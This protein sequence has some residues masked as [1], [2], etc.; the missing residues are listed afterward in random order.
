MLITN[1]LLLDTMKKLIKN[2]IF[3]LF[4]ALAFSCNE[5]MERLLTN[6]YP[7]SGTEYTTGHVLM[8]VIDGASGI[9]V[10]EAY[11]T[12]K[13]PVIRSMTDKSMFT[14][15]GL[16]DSKEGVSKDRGWANLLTGTT[17]NGLDV[18]QD[19]GELETPSFL[20]RLKEADENLKVSFYSSDT[21]FFGAFG[22]VADTKKKTS[23]DS[24]TTDALIAEINGETISDIVV[25]QFGG[26][27]Q[28]GEQYGFWKNET[29]PTTEVIDAIYDVDVLIGK[30]MKALETR[31]LY[32]QEN[33][34][35]VITS[36]YGGVYEGDITPA[37]L[38]DDPRL[39]SFMMLYNSRFASKLL[40]KPSSDELQYKF[41]SPYFV[42]P[43]QKAT[44]NAVMTDNTDF[45]NMGKR[46]SSD[47]AEEVDKSGYT[48]QFKMFDAHGD[49]WGN[50]NIISKRNQKAGA[51][52]QLMFSGNTQVE[53]AADFVDGSVLRL[54]STRRDKLWH[55]YTLVIKEIDDTQKGDSILFYLDGVYQTGRKIDGSKDVSTDMPLAIGHTFAPDRPSQANLYVNDLQFYNVALPADII[56]EYHCTTKLDLLGDSYPYWDNLVAYYPNDREDD[57]GLSYLEDYSKYTSKDKRLYFNKPVGTFSPTDDVVTRK[58][59]SIVTPQVCPLIDDSYYKTVLNTVDL[60]YQIFQ[61]FGESINSS[62]NFDGEGWALEYVF[63]NN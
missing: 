15:Y 29:T 16:A 49:P 20:Q 53:F 41:Y 11:N 43:G 18:T 12:R 30:M 55:S 34:L 23:T 19:I 9:A 46:W 26:V 8:V 1:N 40:Q 5:E 42:G 52:W 28:A 35:V 27:Q 33:W 47:P 51:G 63:F 62:W 38:Y 22:A 44:T 10:N 36:S 50:R 25:A 61:W 7:E 14:F 59:E 57:I 54:P 31:P 17:K 45:F 13:A 2:I 24:E 4:A 48:I 58:Q 39:N 32:V 60:P 3:C 21:S 37:S 6:D 56:A